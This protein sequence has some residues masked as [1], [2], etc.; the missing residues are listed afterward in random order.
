MDDKT[1]VREFLVSRRGRL[2]PEQAGLPAYGATRRV[3]GLR[4]EEVAMLAGVSVDYYV[5]LE[6]G[7]LSGVSESVL[8]ALSR[9]LQ[10]DEAERAH[11]F[12]LARSANASPTAR[13]RVATRR[14]RPQVQQMLDA[15]G[16]PAWV[17]SDRGDFLAGNV[18]GHALYSEIFRDPVRPANTVRFTFLSPRARDFFADW[19]ATADSSVAILRAAA[20]R[21]PHDKALSDLVG[22][23]ATRS[24][25]FRV[26]W[27]AHE[28]AFHRTGFKRLHH[29]VVGDLELNYEG[30]ELTADVGLTLF[31]YSAEPGSV[32][33]ERLALLASWA[34]SED[35]E[36]KEAAA[37][38][39]DSPASDAR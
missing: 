14:V 30:M 24:E 15:M 39:A 32:S 5:R 16:S 20:G 6:R 33:A 29:P 25:D 18:L 13:R 4:R 11:L 34:L 7:A 38:S 2:T 37:A 31:V 10:L 12:D 36:A 8:E 26:R 17:R 1:Q 9:A 28:V 22:E 35:R 19:E 27:A 3:S 23:L 21:D